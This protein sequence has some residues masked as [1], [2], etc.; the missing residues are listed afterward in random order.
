MFYPSGLP[1]AAPVSPNVLLDAI[2]VLALDILLGFNSDALTRLIVYLI[3]KACSQM[4]QNGGIP[5][6][7]SR[8]KYEY[9]RQ[10]LRR[11][12]MQLQA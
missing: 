4:T 9:I 11:V 12:T 5:R 7:H 10:P 8:A 3:A 6:K 1:H 2:E